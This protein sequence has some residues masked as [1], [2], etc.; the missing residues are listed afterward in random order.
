V[1]GRGV[2]LMTAVLAAAGNCGHGRNGPLIGAGAPATE[3]RDELLV[4]TGDAVW[5]G[6]LTAA[7]AT[8]TRLADRERGK[9]DSALDFWSELLALLRCEPL[10]KVPRANRNDPA[11]SD[12]WDGLRRLAQIERVRLAREG[13]PANAA[14]GGGHLKVGLGEQQMVWP[15]EKERWTDELPMPAIVSRCAAEPPAQAKGRDDG[16]LIPPMSATATVPEV[17]LVASAAWSLPAEHPATPLLLVQAAVLSIGRGDA[18]A[19]I[20]PLTRLDELAAAA[21]LAPAERERV[22]LAHALAALSAPTTKP[23]VLL[24]KGRAALALKVN[25]PARRA[26]SLLLAER[27]A[28]AGRVDDAAATLGPPPHGDD[29]I[30]RY[31]AFKQMEMHVR[32]GRGGPLLAEAR[33]VLGRRSHAEVEND[34]A[35][36]AVM[37]IAL[38]TLLTSPISDETLEVLESLG[39]PRERLGRAEAFAQ[40]ALEAGVFRSAM[41][42]F[43]WLY[44]NDSDPN[45]QL[46]N[47]A[48]ASVA[49]ARAGDRAEFTRTFRLLAGQEDRLDDKKT[50]DKKTA[51]KKTADKKTADKKTADKKTDRG[52]TPDK[53][54]PL[55]RRPRDSGL[56]ASAESDRAR[57][58]KRAAR[59]V[60]WQRALL[61]VARDA[62]PAL[63]ENDD[64]PNLA[65]LVDT[66]KRHLG[67][68]GRGPVD[69]ELTTLYRA[70][71][72]HLKTGARAY[73]E[74]VGANRRPIL[75][76]DVLIG[77]KYDVP[78]PRID[79]SRALDEIGMLVFVP[80][81]GNDASSAAIERWP[82]RAGVAWTGS[83]S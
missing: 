77:R 49:A 40:T 37:D 42:T 41:A 44:E 43:L 36:T 6:D 2:L 78:A 24:A 34:P 19:A 46:Q 66:L 68:S 79:L 16:E 21:R 20:E 72:A 67:D 1:N 39:P 73:A 82:G 22:V 48:R 83:R 26:L 59:S 81:R 27:L 65:T 15:V 35:S 3:T 30:G 38:R 71:S 5:R 57:E 11:L 23:D 74:T 64:Q 54:D 32:A 12:P 56:I 63:V 4:A 51:D 47:L 13:V 80:R 53:P 25:P 69:E 9:A 8:L 29:A 76:G 61:V 60:N 18:K 75:L 58:K 7:H 31:I 33:E 62:L 50:A 52:D 10:A 28:A 17:A 70:A 14:A 55:E 45:R